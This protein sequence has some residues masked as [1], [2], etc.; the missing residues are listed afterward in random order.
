MQLSD[1]IIQKITNEGPVSFHDFMEIC[2]YYPGSGYYT[3]PREKIGMNGDFY[4]TSTLTAVFGAMIGRQ[5]EE[6]WDITGKNE[7]IIVEY[8]AGTGILCQDILNYLKNN[9]GFYDKLHY[10]IIEKSPA[11]QQQ[12]KFA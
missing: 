4:T 8:G 2:L 10:Y 3:S 11:M 12:Q 5:L 7:F 9:P 1:T 6:M